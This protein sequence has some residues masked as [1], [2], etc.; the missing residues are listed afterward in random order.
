MKKYI[1]LLVAFFSISLFA[2]QADPKAT[3]AQP[4]SK[5]QT[6]AA[7]PHKT[8]RQLDAEI[9]DGVYKNNY[10]GF[11]YAIP[12][13]WDS[14]DEETKKRLIEM[15]QDQLKDPKLK[16]QQTG[17]EQGFFFLLMTTPKDGMLPQ[18]TLMAQDVVLIP[19]IKTGADFISLL[20]LEFK[21]QP[22]YSVLKET[23]KFPIGDQEFYRSDFKNGPV[24]Q[25]AIFTIMRRHAVGFIVSAG[26]DE[27]IQTVIHTVQKLKFEPVKDAVTQ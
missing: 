13:G 3:A 15:G 18:V 25:S 2:Q 20:N 5:A 8:Y 1:V 9:K 17:P 21:Q 19:Q 27:D 22:G 4:D 6:P 12:E 7:A 26:T 24:F 16:N 23:A 10:F 14:H 11:S